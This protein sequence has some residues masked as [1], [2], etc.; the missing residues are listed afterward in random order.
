MNKMKIILLFLFLSAAMAKAQQ[1]VTDAGRISSIRKG[2]EEAA[3]RT[4]T[5]IASFT[6]DK[7][8]SILDEKLSSSGNFYFKK[9]KMLRWEYTRPYSYIIVINNDRITIRDDSKTSQFDTR[10]KVFS[11]VNRIIVGSIRGTL[12]NDEANFRSSFAE[13]TSSWVVKLVPLTEGLKETLSA[14]TLWFDKKDF[15]VGKLEMTEVTGDRTVI[16]FTEKRFNESIA[17]EK[18]SVK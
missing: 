18:F 15:S 9:E 3:A 7:E 16:T 14:I 11:E 6:Q 5:I 13:S 2:V 17:D 10:N 8:M 1:P 4:A 12:L